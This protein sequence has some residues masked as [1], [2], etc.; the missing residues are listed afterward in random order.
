MSGTDDRLEDGRPPRVAILPWGDVIED[1]LDAIG[2]SLDAFATQMEGGWL[3]GYA[4]A[5]R[6]AGVDSMVVCFSQQLREPRTFTHP[7]SGLQT[8]VLPASG[9][10]LSLRRRMRDPY[11]RTVHEAVGPRA[12]PSRWMWKILRPFIPYLATPPARLR[13]ELEHVGCSAILCQEYESARFDV[14]VAVGRSLSLP[15][16]ASFQGG[17]SQTSPLESWVRPWSLR[18]ASGLV[19]GPRR[20]IERVEA[21]YALQGTPVV[22]IFNPVDASGWEG[23]SARP[24]VRRELGIPVDSR[25][26]VWHGRVD[27]RRKGLDVLVEAWRALRLRDP[28]ANHHLLLVGSGR[29]DAELEGALAELGALYASVTW[30]R[31]FVLDRDRIKR[32]LA[33]GDIYVFPSRHEGF[34]VAPLEAM[35]AG[36][37]LV[38]ADAPGV[39]DVL[40]Q[41]QLCGGIVVPTGDAVSLAE[42]LMRLVSDP[43]LTRALGERAQVRVR[44]HFSLEAVGKELAGFLVPGHTRVG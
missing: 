30:V 1:Y 38:G 43:E 2:V 3:F 12:W 24:A 33:A 26:V 39:R 19:I 41:P 36:L 6:T 31:E 25:V 42:A 40:P 20:E 37:P 4:D 16:F 10:Y 44:E 22:Q 27:M 34:A 14:A 13:R 11:G 7:Q 9:L 5:L 15:V 18:A 28:E 23:P 21:T 17:V 29:D 32:L 35:A 8:R